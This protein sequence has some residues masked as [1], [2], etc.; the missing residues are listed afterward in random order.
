MEF[1]FKVT[2][3]F[4]GIKSR[5]TKKGIG[6]E[7]GVQR[8][9]ITEHRFEGRRIADRLILVRRIRLLFYGHFRMGRFK[10]II[11]KSDVTDN[12]E[13]VGEDRGLVSIAEMAVVV[14][15][16]CVIAGSSV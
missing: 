3:S 8:E 11:Q 15:L 4:N 1:I 10:V 13:S 5:I 16:F 9:K 12:A 6:V 14:E 2:V 7:T